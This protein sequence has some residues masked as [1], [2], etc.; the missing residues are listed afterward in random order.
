[1]FINPTGQSG[2]FIFRNFA[3]ATTL[4]LV[5]A[6]GNVLV[7]TGSLGIGTTTPIANFQ[8]ANG[9]NATTTVEFGSSGQNKGTC[10]KLYRS[11]GSAIYAS[12]AAGATT[13]TL[14]TTACASVTGF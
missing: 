10:I 2:D 13:F 5:D 4:Q 8:V 1:M 11:D 12:V 7:P 3:L 9:T 14:S 6:S